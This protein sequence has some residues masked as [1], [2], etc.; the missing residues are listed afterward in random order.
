MIFRRK[1]NRY[2]TDCL[3]YDAVGT[4]FGTTDIIPLWVADMDIPAPAVIRR[5]LR[6]RVH[7]PIYGYSIHNEC[8]FKSII[9]W[10][11]ERFGWEIDKDWITCTPGIVPAINIAVMSLTGPGDEIIIQPPVYPPFFKAVTDHGRELVT[12]PLKF[13]DGRY[14]FD[15][16]DLKR[17]ITSKTK[18]LILCSPHNPVGRVFSREELSA[19]GDICLEH[20]ITIVSDEIHADIVFAP[21]RHIPVAAIS[22]ELSAITVTCMAPSKTFNIAG[23][24]TSEIIIENQTLRDKFRYITQSLHICN[25]NILGDAALIAAYQH[26][27]PWLNRTLKFLEE[28]IDLVV[29]YISEHIPM[30]TVLKPESTFLLWLDCRKLGLTQE[31]L[32]AFFIREAGL[33]LNDG[34]TFGEGGEGFMRM[35][36]GTCRRTLKKALKQL[37]EALENKGLNQ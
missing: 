18:M 13:E 35:N 1:I 19:L 12:N 9:S 8:F 20:G 37:K 2:H 32:T 21:A 23:F 7:H 22:P 33:G 31:E 17:K 34:A 5:A 36:I 27:K 15:L 25:G 26:G 16:D 30:I 11:H 24:A 6:K 10:M 4:V 3:K 28:N 14:T 29:S